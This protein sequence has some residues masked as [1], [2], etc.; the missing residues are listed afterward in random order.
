MADDKDSGTLTME[1]FENL[2]RAT[3]DNYGRPDELW[4]AGAS[5]EGL[6]DL[7]TRDRLQMF[8]R[9]LLGKKV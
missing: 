3:M 1:M 5:L 7:L 2:M 6:Q 9:K 4:V 8:M